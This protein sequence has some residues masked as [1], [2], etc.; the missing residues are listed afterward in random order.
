MFC[1]FIDTDVI[2]TKNNHFLFISKQKNSA[3]KVVIYRK[4]HNYLFSAFSWNK[5]KSKNTE[6]NKQTK[7]TKTNGIL[8]FWEQR[9]V[10]EEITSETEQRRFN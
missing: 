2:S 3:I 9:P 1:L 6:K 10:S 7:D 4:I 5:N 8:N